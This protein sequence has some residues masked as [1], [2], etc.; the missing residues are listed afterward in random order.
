ME[1][2]QARWVSQFSTLHGIL[3]QTVNGVKEDLAQWLDM[4]KALDLDEQRLIRSRPHFVKPSTLAAAALAKA[5]AQHRGAPSEPQG[6]TGTKV[7]RD[8]KP[9][10]KRGARGKGRYNFSSADTQ[11]FYYSQTLHRQK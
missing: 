11:L 8:G 9:K 4:E 7:K 1:Q 5:L 6:S 10:S 3:E 2:C